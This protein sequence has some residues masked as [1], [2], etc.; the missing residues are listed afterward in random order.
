MALD[1]KLTKVVKKWQQTAL[2]MRMKKGRFV[3]YTTDRKRYALPL[4]LL[5]KEIFVELLK[6]SE[7]EFGI[8]GHQ[9]IVFPFDSSVMDHIIHVLISNK[10]QQRGR[11]HYYVPSKG[12]SS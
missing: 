4:E 10:Q 9:P 8:S 5:E 2:L 3:V 1:K 11:Q 6:M 12:C 7:E